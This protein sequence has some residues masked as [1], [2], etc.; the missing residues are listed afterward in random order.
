MTGGTADSTG[1]LASDA[2]VEGARRRANFDTTAQ[3]ASPT[4]QMI[5]MLSIRA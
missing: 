5:S 3:I 1:S 4:N 2:G